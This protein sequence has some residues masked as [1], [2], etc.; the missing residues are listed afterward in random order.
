[1]EFLLQ[2]AVNAGGYS[3][4]GALKKTSR[5]EGKCNRTLSKESVID[6]LPV[7]S[8]TAKFSHSFVE[9]L[10]DEYRNVSSR[11]KKLKTVDI[12]V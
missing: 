6:V 9:A 2:L 10:D 7:E 3:F 11:N 1:M 12:Y 5:P 8:S 4:V